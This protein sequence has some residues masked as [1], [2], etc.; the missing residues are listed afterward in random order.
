M[1]LGGDVVKVSG[2]LRA[3]DTL[4]GVLTV[5][6][7][8][9]VLFSP[10]LGEFTLLVLLSLAFIL[11]GITVLGKGLGGGHSHEWLRVLRA[12]LGL[13]AILLGILVLASPVLGLVFLTAALAAALL[14]LGVGRLAPG[15]SPVSVGTHRNF[16]VLVGLFDIGAAIVVFAFPGLA[17]LT[18]ILVLSFALLVT[19]LHDIAVGFTGMDRRHA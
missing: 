10:G 16:N 12:L 2:P 5:V 18:L 4:L 17:V 6:I 13:F 14:L 15:L 7:A 1:N 11:A 3:F 8:V 9:V 19:G